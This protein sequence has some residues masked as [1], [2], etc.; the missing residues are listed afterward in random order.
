[1]IEPYPFEFLPE[2]AAWWKAKQTLVLSDVHLGKAAHFRKNG[3]AIPN[4]LNRDNLRRLAGLLQQ[5]RAERIL[6]IGD[7]VHS[8]YNEE[9]DEFVAM[10]KEFSS[11]TWQLVQG[12]HDVLPASMLEDASIHVCS[13]LEEEGL[14]FVHE[15]LPPEEL[16]RLASSALHRVCG[17]VHPAVRLKGQGRQYLRLPCF[18]VT[19]QQ[20]IL[21]AFGNFTGGQLIKSAPSDRVIAVADKQ[22]FEV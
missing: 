6:I 16:K 17:H 14:L 22:L 1:M 5:H 7:L 11:C 2:K 4:T 20:T 19:E 8:S 18:W 9:W 15:P 12:N 3:L 13:E 10:R 21:P